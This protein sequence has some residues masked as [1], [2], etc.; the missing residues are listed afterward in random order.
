MWIAKCSYIQKLPDPRLPRG[1]PCRNELWSLESA[2]DKCMKDWCLGAGRF[3][4]EHWVGLI[5]DVNISD[6]SGSWQNEQGSIFGYW[7]SYW[8]LEHVEKIPLECKSAPRKDLMD[9]YNRGLLLPQEPLWA[10]QLY[11]YCGTLNEQFD[12]KIYLDSVK[13]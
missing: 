3:R 13:K 1:F 4:F 12:A 7:V 8:G 9:L 6:C 11:Q 10:R 2:K 5:P